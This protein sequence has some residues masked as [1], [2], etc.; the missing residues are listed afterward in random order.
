MWSNVIQS[1][2]AAA[3]KCCLRLTHAQLFSLRSYF[4]SHRFQRVGR[5]QNRILSY[6]IQT[7][8]KVQ[9]KF[10][11]CPTN[12]TR[13][14]TPLM[15][16]RRGFI[17]GLFFPNLRTGLILSLLFTEFARELVGK[18]SV[19]ALSGGSLRNEPPLPRVIFSPSNANVLGL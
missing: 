1:N 19:L 16:R 12:K 9:F 5:T 2:V 13:K 11:W 4:S 17:A 7:R 15:R 3:L 6:K 10:F 8:R 14:I 18:I